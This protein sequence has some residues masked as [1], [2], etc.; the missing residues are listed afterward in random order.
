MPP[1]LRRRSLSHARF[2]LQKN[3]YPNVTT[4]I[5][6]QKLKKVLIL[7]CLSP[8]F[9]PSFVRKHTENFFFNTP[10]FCSVCM[11]IFNHDCPRVY[12]VLFFSAVFPLY[13]PL[14]LNIQSPSQS[15]FNSTRRPTMK[16]TTST[17]STITNEGF[18]S[19][20]I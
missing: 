2:F 1:P 17:T 8:K 6:P 18:L 20:H 12:R 10:C 19:A 9:T 15:K 4:I 3:S 16:N 5:I 7:P 11:V 13:T 14:P